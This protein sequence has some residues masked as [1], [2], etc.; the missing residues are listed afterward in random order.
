[1]VEQNVD[2]LANAIVTHNTYELE[3]ATI[4]T[5]KKIIY[6]TS[7]NEFITLEYQ[8]EFRFAPFTTRNA[9]TELIPFELEE[10]A[11][12]NLHNDEPLAFDSVLIP[13][14]T[15]GSP[16]QEYDQDGNVIVE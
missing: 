2:F 9:Q 8:A 15:P 1:L 11:F 4:L 5:H 13:S 10:L 14:S 6:D 7:V 12:E 3:G 16:I